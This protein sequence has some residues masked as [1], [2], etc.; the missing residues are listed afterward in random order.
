MLTP[1]SAV[2]ILAQVAERAD[3]IDF[4]RAETAKRRAEDRL[5][6]PQVTD[7]DFERVRI[8]MLR[9]LT[10]LQVSRH[11]KRGG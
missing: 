7:V 3:D 11:T 2:S 4:Q 8:A 5:A 9:A 1:S 6:K 10:R